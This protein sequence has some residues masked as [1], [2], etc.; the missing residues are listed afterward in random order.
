[1]LGQTSRSC[2]VASAIFLAICAAPGPARAAETLCDPSVQ[3]CRTKLL[4]LIDAELMGI[5]V[6]FWF[7]EDSR[8]ADRIIAR[9]KAGVP[10]RLIIDPRANPGYPLNATM[11][12]KFK[13]AGI[14]MIKKTAGGIMHW[15]TMVFAGQNTVEF[16]SANYSDNAFVPLAPYTDY[17][18]ETIFY[19]DDP[20]IVNS[21]KTKF[22]NVW[23]DTTNYSAYANVTS[24][25]RVYPT[26]PIGADLNF[27]PGQSYASRL[28][29][30]EKVETQKI[31]VH[32]YRVT[33]QSHSDAMIAAHNRGVP[34]R[35]LGET[36]E[37]RDI[38]R[39]W[40][41]W[42]MDRM[43]AAGI[44]M[45]VRGQAGEYHEKLILLYNQG[46]AVFG[47]SNWTSASDNSQLEHN[48]FTTKQ[49]M[50]QWF[51]DQFNRMWNNSHGETESVPFVPL[52]PNTPSYRSIANG[53]TGVPTTGQRLVWYGGPWA[54]LYDIYFGTDPTALTVLAADRPLGPSE[55]TSQTQ[56]WALPA[57][58]TGTTYYWKIVSKTA[59][60]LSRTGPVWSFTT[61]GS[62]SGGQLPAPWLDQDI[63]SVGVAGSAQFANGTFT[64]SASGA[65]IWGTADAFHYAYQSWSGDG[66][67]VARIGG[68]ANTNAWAK[69]GVMFRTTLN[70]NSAHAFMV[71]T[72]ANGVSFQRRAVAGGSSVH[73]TVSG[74]TPPRWVRLDR[75]GTTF[76]A[77]YSSDGTSWTLVGTDT[78]AMP[79]SPV[80][81]GMAVT[82]HNDTTHTTAT[83]D[84]VTVS[85]G[86]GGGGSG[87]PPPWIERD[88]GSVGLAGSAQVANGTFTVK[89]SGADIWGTA[90]AFH[91]VYQQWTGDGSIVARVAS[92]T[93]T[94]AWAKAGVMVRATLD[95][96]SQHAFMLLS[97]ANGVAFQRRATAGG[98]SVS[99]AVA[100]VAAPRWVR[101]DRQGNIFSAYYSSDG[102]TWTPVGTETIALPATLFAGIAVTSHNNTALTTA[103][104]DSVPA[105]Q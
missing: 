39:I 49:W 37:Y 90:D 60:M 19:S 41:S 101:L 103:T 87:L 71:L 5:D 66:S 8:Y 45:R 78:I 74:V 88:I 75:S 84:S 35:Y 36:R 81:V 12:D 32:M 93:N 3:N 16:G 55:T 46:T 85:Q 86:S 94:S 31:D 26:F 99:T 102:T 97:A 13:Q 11:L 44:P 58:Q 7:M 21:F 104:L 42:N 79:V 61:T 48:Y 25:V 14:P 89:A 65:D 57:L 77:Y 29:A 52:P 15:K 50:F 18:S 80:F 56:S 69:A 95:A 10:V 40:V 100:G 22:D 91:Y 1:M 98:T 34:V 59:A 33:Q 73:T 4:S 6:S 24:R 83:L 70:A 92:V 64:V 54:H 96:N 27:P 53:A 68:V 23:T 28:I 62:G 76:T 20:A 82:S 38:N 51:A 67:I 105:Q 17:V 2:I 30:L 63:G 47:S 9:W 43:Y 72:A